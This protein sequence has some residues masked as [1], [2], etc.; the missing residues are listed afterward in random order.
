MI[1]TEDATAVDTVLVAGQVVVQKK[2]LLTI[3][4]TR[5]KQQAQEAVE[6]LG[7]QN[8]E[9]RALAEQLEHHV[10]HFCI[11]LARAPHHVHALL[12]PPVDTSDPN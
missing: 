1:H 7:Q 3:D 4:M 2:Q 5:L 10:G 11:G 9:S 12:D 8:T 6:S